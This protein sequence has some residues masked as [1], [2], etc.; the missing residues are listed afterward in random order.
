[1]AHTVKGQELCVGLLNDKGTYSTAC[2][3]LGPVSH[4]L[5]FLIHE[6]VRDWYGTKWFFSLSLYS[7]ARHPESERKRF[8]PC[9]RNK[10]KRKDVCRETGG[11]GNRLGATILW[12][13]PVH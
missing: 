5:F 3:S 11:P 13:T 2:P 8:M 12:A 10:D 7:N 1:M 9:I 4:F 6:M